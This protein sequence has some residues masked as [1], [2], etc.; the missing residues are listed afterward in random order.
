MKGEAEKPVVGQAVVVAPGVRRILAPNPGPMTFWGTNTYLMGTDPVAVVDPGP[1]VPEH[2]E[3]ILAALAGTKVA[4]V[5]VTHAHRDHSALAPALA[6]A[7]GAPVM[8]FGPPDAGRSALMAR[9][10]ETEELGGGEGVDHTFAPDKVLLDGARLTVGDMTITALHTPGH[11]AGHLSFAVG[12]TILTGD[13]IMG[14]ST[15]LISPPDGD[16][17]AFLQSAGRLRA[18]GAR[19]FLPGHGP[20]IDQPIARLDWLITHRFDRERQMCAALEDGGSLTAA[21]LAAA[22]YHDLT[23]DLLP[24]AARNVLAHLLDLWDRGKVHPSDGPLDTARWSKR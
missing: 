12:D 10:A 3:A 20:A 9:V 11:F 17:R 21:G 19:R 22:I 7:V 24:A 23:P 4:C 8:G 1:K 6:R 15:T 18:L 13:A 2:K 5:L 14:W 16:V